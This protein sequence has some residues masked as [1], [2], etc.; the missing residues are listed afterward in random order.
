MKMICICNFISLLPNLFTIFHFSL[1]TDYA[2]LTVQI[3]PAEAFLFLF[4]FLK[5]DN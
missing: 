3:D 4:L 5:D 2:A 1:C